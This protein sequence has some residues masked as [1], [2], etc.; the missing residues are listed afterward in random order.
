MI[1]ELVALLGDC[2]GFYVKCIRGTSV[3]LKE[4]MSGYL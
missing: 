4:A 1:M 2:Q 3:M